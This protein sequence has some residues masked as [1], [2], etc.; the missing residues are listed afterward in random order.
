MNLEVGQTFDGKYSILSILGKGGMGTVY[1]AQNIK[2]GTLWAIK[3]VNKNLNQSIDL[4]AEPNIMKKLNHPSLPRIFDI[5]ENEHYLYIVLDYV[6][7][8]SLDKELKAL[9]RIPERDVVEW[10]KQ[11]CEV[12][13]YLHEYRPN[14]IIYRDMKPSNLMR[15]PDGSIKVIDFGIAREYKEESS[16]DTQKLGTDG[17]AAPEQRGKAQTDERSDIY[18]LGVTLYHLVTGLGPADIFEFKPIRQINPS[19]SEGLEEILIKT[20]RPNPNDRYQ[21]AKELLSDL[22]NIDKLSS[23]YKLERRKRL[24]ISLSLVSSLCFFVLLTFGGFSEIK[25]SQFDEYNV[26]IKEGNK[27]IDAYQFAEAEK[28]FKKAIEKLPE[29]SDAY[30]GLVKNLY[31][32][33]KYSDSINYAQKILPLIKEDKSIES[34]IYYYIGSAYFETEDFD[35]AIEY[36][37]KASTLSPEYTLYQRDLAV[38]LAKNGQT[39][40]AMD[41][42]EKMEKLNLDEEV[43]W[44]LTGEISGAEGK[45]EDA[46]HAFEKVLEEGND[47]Y[48]KTKST[49]EIAKLYKNNKE[50]LKDTAIDKRIKT[51]ESGLDKSEG[52][53]D[54][55]II[56]MLAEAYYE[57]ALYE[58]NNTSFFEKSIQRFTQ[59]LDN[60][61][62]RPYLYRNIAIIYQ[63]MNRLEDSEKTLLLMKEK[64]P[65]EYTCYSQLALLYA[66]MENIKEEDERDFSKVVENY[67]LALKY[68]PEG[69]ATPEMKPLV[70]LINELKDKNWIE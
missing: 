12:Y 25:A 29:E 66:N 57:K 48:I 3:Q 30:K 44:Y 11:I 54:L 14:P 70:N 2:L 56:E 50:L 52:N 37:Q 8:V 15:V 32:Q 65:T 6:E 22:N 28:A 42:L 45:V 51:L 20:L 13:I 33:G 21:S 68:S 4:L 43:T 41:I 26:M 62:E 34:E 40:Q 38:S 49:L 61:Y 67:N 60:G 63:T 1:K 64:Y 59:L 23:A 24:F 18:S 5:I 55:L 19:F 9:G 39:A 46:L 58:N 27:A 53:N 35:K 16:T 10:A 36:L 69:E 17:Y 31:V 47:P 7:G